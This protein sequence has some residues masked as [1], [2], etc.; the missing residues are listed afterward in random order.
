MKEK[1]KQE[2]SLL[3]AAVKD[4]VR[5][6]A[7]LQKTKRSVEGKLKATGSNMSFTQSKESKLRNELSEL[8]SKEAKLAG[9]KDKLQQRLSDVKT[10]LDK[11]SK[12]SRE[13]ESV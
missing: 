10:K 2:K 5:E 12:I 1:L 4:L 6:I 7:E 3:S 9:K 11:V 13:L 8:I